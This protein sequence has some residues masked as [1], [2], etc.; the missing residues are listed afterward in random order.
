MFSYMATRVILDITSTLTLCRT[1]KPKNVDLKSLKSI[2]VTGTTISEEQLQEIRETFPNVLVSQMYGQSEVFSPLTYFDLAKAKHV[3]FLHTKKGSCGLPM[4]GT[5]YKV[6][7]PDTDKVLGPNQKGEI[8]VKSQMQLGGYYNLDSSGIWDSDGYGY[9]DEDYC[10]YVIDRLKEMFPYRV[11][12]IT[13]A[14]IENVINTHPAVLKS[15]V[16]GIP[17]YIDN[18]HAMA[19]VVLKPGLPN[20]TGEEIQKYVEDRLDDPFHLRAGVKF[21]ENFP[22]TPSGKVHRLKLKE[23]VFNEL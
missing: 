21:V 19:L 3:H 22:M 16:I 10:F 1:P 11:K 23:M 15:V 7:D 20:V 18:H 5:C 9:Y 6:V 4:R 2:L 12:H 13:P 14:S 8:R 17:H